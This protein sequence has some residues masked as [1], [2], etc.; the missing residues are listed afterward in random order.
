MLDS[1][2]QWDRN[3][4]VLLNMGESHS[5]FWDNFFWMISDILVWLPVMLIFFYVVVKNKRKES[6]FIFL[7]VILV[8]LLCDQ[9]SSSVMKPLIARPRPSRDPAVMDM[10][11]YV[12]EYKGGLFGFPSSHAANSFG[13]CMLSSL[14]LRY[15]PYTVISFCWAALCAYSRIYLGVHFPLDI[16][17]GTI[18]GLLMGYLSY[19]VYLYLRKRFPVN[20]THYAVSGATTSSGY[21]QSDINL[22][23]IVLLVILFTFVCCAR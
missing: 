5:P 10:L 4:M 7:S 21:L 13:F 12:R 23:I 17:C 1:I 22:L 2:V 6:I 18:L 9:L 14:L 20:Q 8:F 16:L 15:R 3:A 19:R 11:S